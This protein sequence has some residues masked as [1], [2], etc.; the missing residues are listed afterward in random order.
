MA[1]PNASSEGHHV[2]LSPYRFDANELRWLPTGE[3]AAK[4]RMS[5]E[6][7]KN[8]RLVLGNQSVAL[9]EIRSTSMLSPNFLICH[10]FGLRALRAV[11]SEQCAKLFP[12]LC[13]VGQPTKHASRRSTNL[14]LQPSHCGKCR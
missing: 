5:K 13:Q 4:V 10:A 1:A 6:A 3:A 9:S 8:W 14:H 11:R 12:V 7:A 2:I